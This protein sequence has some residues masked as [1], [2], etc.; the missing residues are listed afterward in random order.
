MSASKQPALHQI[1]N[2]EIQKELKNFHQKQFR[3]KLKVFVSLVLPIFIIF[4]TVKVT[5]IYVT[6]K[7]K[8]ILKPVSVNKKPVIPTLAKTKVSKPVFITPEP[9]SCAKISDSVTITDL[10]EEV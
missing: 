7:L 9:V 1:L 8:S 5:Q 6:I 10:G 2:R 4:L 3:F